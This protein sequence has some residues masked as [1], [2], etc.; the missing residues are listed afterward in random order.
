MTALSFT[1]QLETPIEHGDEV[2]TELVLVE[3]DVG[4]L[5]KVDDASGEM[6]QT[7]AMIVACTDLPPSVIK[8]IKLR[9]LRKINEAMPKLSG[10]SQASGA[11]RQRGSP[12]PFT[13]RQVS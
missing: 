2:L 12:I 8:Q 11:R 6:G 7:L 9:D 10:E 4:G 1:I 5:M 13:G 3:P